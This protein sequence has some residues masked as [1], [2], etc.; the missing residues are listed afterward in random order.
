M[1]R[2]AKFAALVQMGLQV[3]LVEC[4]GHSLIDFVGILARAFQ[5]PEEAVP[6]DLDAAAREYLTWQLGAE[7]EPEWHQA[8]REVS[9]SAGE[10]PA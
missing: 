7:D 5:L 8:W 3:V 6:E 10:T 4:G 2:T 1:N 9:T